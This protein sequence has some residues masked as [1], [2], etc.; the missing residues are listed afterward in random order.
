MNTN[1]YRKNLNDPIHR[2]LHA[3]ESKVHMVDCIH[4]RIYICMHTCIH[5]VF[6]NICICNIDNVDINIYLVSDQYSD[7]SHS[8]NPVKTGPK[9]TPETLR[10]SA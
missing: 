4:I 5:R 7:Y 10:L 8:L 6:D 1:E 9:D 2:R 3:C